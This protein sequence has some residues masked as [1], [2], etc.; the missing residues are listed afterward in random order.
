VG[1]VEALAHLDYVLDGEACEEETPAGVRDKGRGGWTL[2]RW[3]EHANAKSAKLEQAE[4]AALR[5][6]TL[7][8]FRHINE[9]MRDQ[10][11][12]TPHP[13]PVTTSFVV[14]GLKKLRAIDAS[15]D[16]AR[17]EMVLFRG[18]KNVEVSDE[19]HTKGGTELAP[20]STT[21]DPGVAVHYSTNSS[22]QSLLFRIIT[23][24]K[25]QRGADLE[26]LSAFPNESEVLFP[27]LTFMQPTGRS[28]VLDIEGQTLTVVE[29][30]DTTV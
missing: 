3:M 25:L 18:L 28:Q 14:Q 23:K 13:L 9:P 17:Q 2:G 19:F 7:P 5:F 12:T 16:A 26:W 27:P 6:Y 29:V 4:V 30:E 1:Y 22:G 8:A 10:L 11:R 24:N 15:S 20:M 21:S